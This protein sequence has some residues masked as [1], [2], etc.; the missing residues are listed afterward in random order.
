MKSRDFCYWLQGFFELTGGHAD[1]GLSG[2]QAQI[3]Q[4]H[5]ALVFKHDLN[6]QAQIWIDEKPKITPEEFKKVVDDLREKATKPNPL[7]QPICQSEPYE[8][9]EWAKKAIN[10]VLTHG[11]SD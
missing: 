6:P 10:R 2:E 3:I 9:S 5:L 7:N 1:R 8:F 4:R 11:L